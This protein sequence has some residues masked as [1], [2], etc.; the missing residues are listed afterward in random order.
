MAAETAWDYRPAAD[1]DLAR[2]LGPKLPA[3]GAAAVRV[4]DVFERPVDV[5]RRL[6][7]RVDYSLGSV[8]H[9]RNNTRVVALKVDAAGAV[10]EV[11]VAPIGLPRP[12]Q[13]RRLLAPPDGAAD[14]A[15][16]GV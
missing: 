9:R 6:V 7:A 14:A 15:D 13:Y 3:V 5:G 2:R 12:E 10:R 1:D 8:R 16:A 11:L 4:T